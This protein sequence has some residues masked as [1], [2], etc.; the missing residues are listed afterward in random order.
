MIKIAKEHK[1][2][3]IK[4][5]VDLNNTI[6]EQMASFLL[7]LPIYMQEIQRLNTDCHMREATNFITYH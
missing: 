5:P 4:L 7:V 3:W 6:N 1:L 2:S